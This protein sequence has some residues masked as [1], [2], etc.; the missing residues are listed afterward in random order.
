M[1]MKPCPYGS[2][3]SHETLWRHDKRIT[4]LEAEVERLQ[5]ECLALRQELDAIPT[6]RADELGKIEYPEELKRFY[7]R[8][9][10]ESDGEARVTAGASSGAVP[11]YVAANPAAPSGVSPSPPHD[12]L[13]HGGKSIRPPKHRKTAAPCWCG[14]VHDP[15]K[16]ELHAARKE[17]DG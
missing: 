4:E 2:K 9:G 7:K 12:S 14:L 13:W 16:Y 3:V 8:G 15:K 5:K 1:R 17:R 6:M 10:R 11:R